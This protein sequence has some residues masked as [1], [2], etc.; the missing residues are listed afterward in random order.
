VALLAN[1]QYRKVIRGLKPVEIPDGYWVN[2]GVITNL[3]LAI[4]GIALTAYVVH[5]FK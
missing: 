4:L 5:G 3:A 2:L 1:V